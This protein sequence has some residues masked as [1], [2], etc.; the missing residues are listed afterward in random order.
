MCSSRIVL[1]AIGALTVGA[2]SPN[3]AVA[4][5]ASLSSGQILQRSMLAL[6]PVRSAHSQSS[7]HVIGP[8]IG[9]KTSEQV[10]A[11]TSV[12]CTGTPHGAT[13][14][15]YAIRAAVRGTAV[16][17]KGLAQAINMHYIILSSGSNTGSNT[18]TVFW[19]RDAT[20]T[21][22]WRKVPT[23]VQEPAYT[24]FKAAD[25]C[26]TDGVAFRVAQGMPHTRLA[27]PA[28]GT[29]LGRPVWTVAGTSGPS[30]ER[31]S[32]RLLVDR[33]NYRLDGYAETYVERINGH[34]C[35]RQTI[36]TTYSRYGASFAI[37]APT[38]LALQ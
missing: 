2:W 14:Y 34:V 26:P 23:V 28:R 31:F 19:E 36:G 17:G 32:F 4:H 10:T 30:S 1:F 21:N 15:R 24:A 13:R 7:V 9:G 12:D 38:A 6:R 35:C 33:A 18:R 8:A 3:D 5:F 20:R 22:R 37:T 25:V 27:P 29:S 16:I 11:T